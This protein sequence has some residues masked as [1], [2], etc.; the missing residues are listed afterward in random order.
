MATIGGIFRENKGTFP[1]EYL[2][3][4]CDLEMQGNIRL[5][6]GKGLCTF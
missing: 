3:L 5:R 1:A 2:K 6:L 4:G